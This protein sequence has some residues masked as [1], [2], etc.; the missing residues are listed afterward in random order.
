V[1]PER[2]VLPGRAVLPRRFD[3]Y[4]SRRGGLLPGQHVLPW[5]V[6]CRC[7]GQ[8]SGRCPGLVLSGG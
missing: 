5:A 8:H 6:L 7:D 3:P 1:L 2:L 4:Q